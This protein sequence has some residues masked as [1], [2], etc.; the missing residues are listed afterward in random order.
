MNA[1]RIN[2]SDVFQRLTA[3]V[4]ETVRQPHGHLGCA[5]WPLHHQVARTL[6]RLSGMVRRPRLLSVAA[7]SA[8]ERA[9]GCHR[10]RHV[11]KVLSQGNLGLHLGSSEPHYLWEELFPDLSLV[12]GFGRGQLQ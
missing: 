4:L 9:P 2:L 5:V 11:G 1:H 3:L 12:P 6:A 8:G 7:D 10:E